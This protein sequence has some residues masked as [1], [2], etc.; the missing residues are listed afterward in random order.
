MAALIVS[1][2]SSAGFLRDGPAP[3]LDANAVATDSR[4]S[5]AVNRELVQAV[6]DYNARRYDT[7]LSDLAA[8][9][10]IAG[11][12]S[13]D[14]FQI[15]NVTVHVAVARSDFMSGVTAAEAM[16]ASPALTETNRKSAY[17]N[18]LVMNAGARHYWRAIQF[19]ELLNREGLLDASTSE[20]LAKIYLDFG[21]YSDGERIAQAALDRG[22][23]D[24]DER[25]ALSGTLA[26]LQIKLGKREP[27][28]GQAL[29][30]SLLAGATA[31]LVEGLTGQ[32]VN[33]APPANA[34][35]RSSMAQQAE[36]AAQQRAAAEVLS[37]DATSLVVVYPDLVAQAARLTPAERRQAT[38]TMDAAS[39]AYGSSNFS[40]AQESL[41]DV[42][43]IEPTN[44]TAAFYYA[45][46]MARGANNSLAVID[47]LA[48]AVA[49]D[50]E[51]DAR[52]KA[53]DALQGIASAQQANGQN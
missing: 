35:Q 14:D 51:D 36:M 9:R 22:L 10:S 52:S 7:T 25:K 49:F 26:D 3:P 23:G 12:T 50:G 6:A 43:T 53:R 11:H 30:S 17:D 32:Q 13:Y 8:A 46:C 21:S 41:H 37:Q 45:D 1:T 44:G 5:P 28:V 19:G 34:E 31:G 24:A 16:V 47:Y 2:A 18:A 33:Y 48:R 42:L 29:M 20:T 27:T 38:R 4:L 40:A 39:D 15:N